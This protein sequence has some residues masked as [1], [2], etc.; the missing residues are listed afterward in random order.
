MR[1]ITIAVL[2]AVALALAVYDVIA[3]W[4]GGGASTIS[5]VLLVGARQS[6][7]LVLAF[8]VLLGHLFGQAWGV[9]DR[10]AELA[11]ENLIAVLALGIV[12]GAICWRQR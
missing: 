8:G 9:R 11:S 3:V 4:R 5:A 12:L 2:A 1:A 7:V 10:L 6:P